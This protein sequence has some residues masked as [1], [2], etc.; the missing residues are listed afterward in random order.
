ME[1]LVRAFLSDLRFGARLLVRNPAMTAV[2]V[3]SLGL[4][5]GANTTIFSLINE[6]FLR[7]LPLHE[8]A[9]LVGVFTTDER[10]RA[11]G[12]IGGAAPMSRPNFEDLRDGNRTFEG[13]AA[14]GFIGLGISNGQGEPEQVFA[15]IVTDNFFSLLGPPMAAGRGFTSGTDDTPGAAPEVVLSVGCGSVASAWTPA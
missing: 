15:Q 2:A 13:M 4:G 11:A 5:I 6:V 9:R 8:P 12:P 3:L 7:P 10:N 14:A 1:R